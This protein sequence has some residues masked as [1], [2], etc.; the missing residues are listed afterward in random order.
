MGRWWLGAR[1]WRSS[2]ARLIAG[3]LIGGLLVSGLQAVASSVA[4]SNLDKRIREL[5]AMQTS[6]YDALAATE[7]RLESQR[8]IYVSRIKKAESLLREREGELAALRAQP[9]DGGESAA[10]RP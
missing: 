2:R 7:K 9:L 10:P 4:P 1:W 5:L 8:Q 6:L 3:V